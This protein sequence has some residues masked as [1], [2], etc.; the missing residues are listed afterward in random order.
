MVK[1]RSAWSFEQSGSFAAISDPGSGLPASS[2][3]VPFD[4][5]LGVACLDWTVPSDTCDACPA[6]DDACYDPNCQPCCRAHAAAAKA[7]GAANR[8]GY[9]MC[10]V[11]RRCTEAECW[12]VAQ[13]K[14]YDVTAYV[15]SG[16]HPGANRAILRKAGTDVSED[17]TMHS[18]AARKLWKTMAIG[19]LTK[20]D[21]SDAQTH[22]KGN[23]P[24]SLL[25]W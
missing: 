22:G 20:C 14:I 24:W 5:P 21:G 23:K 4:A 16:K 12:L 9:T 3:V 10:Q 18:K 13:K 7:G 1:G 8:P 11:R 6:C 25:R 19:K 17:L 2:G 15:R